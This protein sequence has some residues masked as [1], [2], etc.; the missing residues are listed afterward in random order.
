MVPNDRL[1]FLAKHQA[2]LNLNNADNYNSTVLCGEI[3]D[4]NSCFDENQKPYDAVRACFICCIYSYLFNDY[5][6]AMKFLSNYRTHIG[7]IA[8]HGIF[9]AIAIFYDALVS[10]SMAKRYE[11][12]EKLIEEATS[13]ISKLRSLCE[14]APM[15][16]EN[17]VC[18]LQAEL[19]AVNGDVNQAIAY[20]QEA[21]ALSKKNKFVNEEGMA[22]ERAGMLLLSNGQ[23]SNASEF[24]LKSH[25]CY[26]EWGAA[27]KLQNLA[28]RYPEIFSKMDKSL[29][30]NVAGIQFEDEC[31]ESVSIMSTA[32]YATSNKAS[33][34][35]RSK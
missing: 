25:K 19:C 8:D 6:L 20:Y 14:T 28:H 32:S 23:C 33:K 4:F 7:Y 21:V 5:R 11:H 17:K 29:R 10:L 16:Y 30:L 1:G 12:Q 24:L 3:F 2:L 34:R 13:N 35:K 9:M 22:N 27:A 26:Y 18:F 31:Q 15:N